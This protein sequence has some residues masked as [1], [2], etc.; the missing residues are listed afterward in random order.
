MRKG[1]RPGPLTRDTRDANGARGGQET[2]STQAVH[3]NESGAADATLATLAM[4]LDRRLAGAFAFVGGI[5][6]ADAAAVRQ[7]VGGDAPADRLV[8]VAAARAARGDGAVGRLADL[9]RAGAEETKTEH[10]PKRGDTT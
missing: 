9:R 2:P 8:D 7:S 10:E 6:L 5:P 4:A 1:P 3:A